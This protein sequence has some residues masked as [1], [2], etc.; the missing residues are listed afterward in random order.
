M[1][2]TS[3]P[4]NDKVSCFAFSLL[5][6]SH[7]FWQYCFHDN[8]VSNTVLKTFYNTLI[9]FEALKHGK[10]GIQSSISFSINP[11]CLTRFSLLPPPLA[12]TLSELMLIRAITRKIK[13]KNTS[14]HLFWGTL[15]SSL[16]SLFLQLSVIVI[17]TVNIIEAIRYITWIIVGSIV[18][19]KLLLDALLYYGCY[20]YQ[21]FSRV[22]VTMIW[23]RSIMVSHSRITVK[24]FINVVIVTSIFISGKVLIW[25]TVRFIIMV[26][27]SRIAIRICNKVI[28]VITNS[29]CSYC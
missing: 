12:L 8:T 17:I 18:L 26:R 29:T 20:Y 24:T 3:A 11:W 4:L 13:T 19:L 28:I 10:H 15:L 22:M 6:G 27:N 16:S 2:L 9:K 25:I 23:I 14:I 7:C 1:K 5:K 21:N